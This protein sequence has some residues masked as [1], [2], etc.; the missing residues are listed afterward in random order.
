[1]AERVCV[2]LSMKSEMGMGRREESA[3]VDRDAQAAGMVSF[4]EKYA[5]EKITSVLKNHA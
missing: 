3:G 5:T 1:M 2:E 4:E